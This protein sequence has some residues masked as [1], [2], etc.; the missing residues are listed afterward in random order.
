M[1]QYFSLGFPIMKAVS[2]LH[3]HHRVVRDSCS[4]ETW[5]FIIT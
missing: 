4:R 2:I 3:H 1:Q 5:L